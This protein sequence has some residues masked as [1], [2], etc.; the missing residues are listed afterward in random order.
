MGDL[1]CPHCL[2]LIPENV[3]NCIFCGKKIK[4][5]NPDFT[6]PIATVLQDRY[7]IGCAI[8]QG[9][10]GITYSACDTRL[11]KKVAIKEY[12]PERLVLRNP[13]KSGEIMLIAYD[14][15]D[16]YELEKANCLQEARTLADFEGDEGVVRV[17]DIFSQNKTVYIVMEFLEGVTLEQYRKLNPDIS[18]EEIYVMLEPIMKVL[19]RIHERGIIHRDIS[20]SNIMIQPDGSAKLLD[21]G[22][23]S[24]YPSFKAH[25]GA[26]LAMDTNP[27]VFTKKIEKLPA[28][29]KPGYAAYEEYD[30]S[31]EIG[32]WTDVY[33]FCAM[34]Y[35]LLTGSVLEPADK[36]N[37][38][39]DLMI[40]QLLLEKLNKRQQQVIMNGIEL[41]KDKR[42]G[43][44]EELMEE[45]KSS[46][47]LDSSNGILSVLSGL[48]TKK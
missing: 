37:E 35:Y 48:F 44:M 9:G 15:E 34:I 30:R 32:P 6:L 13:D 12:Y 43:S 8:G 47:V 36:R 39:T 23:V 17:Q 29:L 38:E 16:L 27:P 3:E 22:S 19:S 20:P 28:L 40:R 26:P 25:G 41:D 14:K 18:F 11:D 21:F 45:L 7:Y 5:K 33:S 1:R 10:F 46:C 2:E 31:V 42:I 24:R 4:M